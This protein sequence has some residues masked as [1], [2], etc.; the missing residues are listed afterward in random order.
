MTWL[1]ELFM[2]SG[3]ED[4]ECALDQKAGEKFQGLH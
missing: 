2:E 4:E 1:P 3:K